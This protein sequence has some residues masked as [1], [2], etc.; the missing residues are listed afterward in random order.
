MKRD[1]LD[2]D[3]VL[4]H[5]LPRA[6]QEEVDAASAI[7]LERIRSMRFQPA[8]SGPR[9]AQARQG[10]AVKNEAVKSEAAAKKPMKAEWLL[11]FHVAIL[12]AVEQLQGQGRP[13]TITLR[14][15]ELLEEPIVWATAVFLILL[16]MESSGMVSSSPI[17]P[18]KP[19]ALDERYY[20]ITATGRQTLAKALAARGRVTDALEGFA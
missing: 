2:I 17:D 10:E 4:K 9:E 14:V 12:M 8:N 13:V 3:E 16:M 20:E 15:E 11:D 19:D 6:S 5:Y 7:V 18:E 1:D